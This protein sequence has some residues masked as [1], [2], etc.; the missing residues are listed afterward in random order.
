MTEQQ[1]RQ[2]IAEARKYGPESMSSRLI[3]R[4][5]DAL[6]SRLSVPVTEEAWQEV[7][8]GECDCVPDLGPSHCHMCREGD[9]DGPVGEWSSAPCRVPVVDADTREAAATIIQATFPTGAGGYSIVWEDC[10][11]AVDAL[12]AAGLLG[13]RDRDA[14]KWREGYRAATHDSVGEPGTPDT[15]NPYLTTEEGQ[16]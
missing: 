14:K 1:D 5:A 15:Q 9:L 10:F 6:E 3:A 12:I 2:L 11:P 4:L 16:E 13:N 8:H 7:R